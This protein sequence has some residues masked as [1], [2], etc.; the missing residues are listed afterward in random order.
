MLVALMTVLLTSCIPIPVKAKVSQSGHVKASSGGIALSVLFSPDFSPETSKSLGGEMVKCI[1]RG[2]AK[3]APEIRLVPE[4][5]FYRAAFGVK[6]G[7]VL[8]QADTIGTLLAQP[9][10]RQRVSESGLTHLILV[11]G[12]TRHHSGGRIDAGQLGQE[13]YSTRI[14][15]L[16]AHIFEL[17]SGAEVAGV[18]ASAEGA[19]GG[20]VFLPFVIIGWVSTTESSSCDA[21]GAQVARAIHGKPPDEIR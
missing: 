1:T 21:L 5:E 11:G 6:P 14:T 13:G 12:A 8:L 20:G 17:A 19:Q 16:F 18:Q 2:I 7:E 3:A 10:V 15:E 4:E 9:D